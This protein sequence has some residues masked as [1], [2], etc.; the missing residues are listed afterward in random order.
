[1]MWIITPTTLVDP[2][3]DGVTFAF[4]IVALTIHSFLSADKVHRVEYVYLYEGT[5]NYKEGLIKL[6]NTLRAKGAHAKCRRQACRES[7]KNKTIQVQKHLLR[8]GI[9]QFK[10]C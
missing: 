7:K 9:I 6:R 8:A 10:T 4:I 3:Y 5:L 1:M 2:I